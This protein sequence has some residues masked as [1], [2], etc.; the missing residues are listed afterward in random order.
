MKTC[1]VKGATMQECLEKASM[2]QRFG[3]A[4]QKP[5]HKDGEVWKIILYLKV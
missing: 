4:V 3:W 1:T 5:I 2:L